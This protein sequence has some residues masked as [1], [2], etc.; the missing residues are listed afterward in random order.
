MTT[1]SLLIFDHDGARFGVD[2]TQV[3]ES[4]W[5]PELTPVEEAPPW[6]VG[7]FNLRGQIIPVADLHLRFDH[8]AR[9]Y[10]TGDHVVVL[11]TDRL[12]LGLIVSEVREVIELP[13]DAIQSP[14]QFDAAVP[15]AMHLVTGEARVGDELVTLL[16]VS[17][18]MHLPEGTGLIEA[19]EQPAPAGYFCPDATPA[20]RALFRKRAM[21]LRETAADEEGSRLG[22][23]VVELGGEYFGVELAAVLEFCDIAELSPI[24]CC[25]PHILGAMSLRGELLTLIDPRSALN[26]P[27]ADR[28][29][30]A[31]IAST[32]TGLSTGFGEQAV[33][34]AVD[35]VHDVVYLRDEELQPAPAALR[36]LCG[37]SIT[38][39]AP[40]AG[41]TMTVLDLPA[42]LAREEWTVN[43]HV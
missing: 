6:I 34:I 5:L 7:L 27:P 36:E 40:Y 30:K 42:L 12:P 19:A 15:G 24:P 3:R 8:P 41:R 32:S 25:P 35:Q 22:L 37:V 10:S 1:Q 20:E 26:L 13:V 39:T 31:V 14:P 16:D 11:E 4:V 29:G 23:A 18:L 9:R 21:A 2:A 33:G 38:G 28:G 43:E 17:R